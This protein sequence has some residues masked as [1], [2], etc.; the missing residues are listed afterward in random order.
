MRV[1]LSALQQR[2]FL[3]GTGRYLAEVFRSLVAQRPDSHFLL[4]AKEDQRSL[5]PFDGTNG[6]LRI[7]SGCPSS[8]IKR[9]LW[10]MANFSGV[11]RGDQVDLYHGPANFLPPRKICPY[12]LTLHDMVYFHNPGRTFYARAKYW[13]WYIRATWRMAD[14][15]IT[16]SEFSK[17]QIMKYIP[18]PADRIH[19]VY[20]GVD[21]RFFA[22]PAPELRARVRSG[23]KLERPYILY[24]GRLDP[25]KN[26]D[27]LVAAYKKFVD[28]GIVDHDLVIAGAKEFEWSGTYKFVMENKLDERVHF[29]G[30]IA[31]DLLVPLYSE[32]AAF[33][34][35]SL[36]EGF[37]LP[38]LE[39]MAAGLPVVTSNISSLPEVIGDAG[40]QA[41]PFS[42]DEIAAG[43][44]KVLQPTTA[45]EFSEA[46]RAR[47]RQFSWQRA[48]EQTYQVYEEVLKSVK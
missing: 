35:P 3:T 10:E 34:F 11:L 27:R 43:L 9:T 36:N 12:V 48:A 6:E 14:S 15:I 24:V 28:S 2:N 41:D 26:V 22:D 32:A 40:V 46:A 18:V 8:P 47:A 37:G 38:V 33:C 25:D 16:V 17:Q 31:D 30:Y 29:T 7:L 13:Q 45:R 44:R 23:M 19:V 1:A 4:Y 42:V 5:F 20:N 21:E 39:A